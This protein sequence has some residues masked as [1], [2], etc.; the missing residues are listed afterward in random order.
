VGTPGRRRFSIAAFL[1]EK[2]QLVPKEDLS[3]DREF[4]MLM[5]DG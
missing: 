5:L 2:S 4:E 3:G 1:S